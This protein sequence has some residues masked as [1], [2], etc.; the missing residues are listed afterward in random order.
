MN[1]NLLDENWIPVLYRDGRWGHVGIRKALEDASQI[2]NIAA[3]NPMDRLAILRF[4]LA[5]LYWCKGNPPGQA[6]P[7]SDD[8]FP[9]EWFS[10]LDTDRDYFN[11]LGEGKRFCQTSVAKRFRPVT[12]LLQEI[13]TGNNFWHF[14]HSIDHEDGLCLPCCAMGLLRL[15]LFSVSGLR[16]LNA[17]INGTPPVYVVH[18]GVSL[19]DALRANWAPCAELGLPAWVSPDIHLTP[20]DDVPLLTGL[21]MLSRRVWLQDP[22]PKGGCVACGGEKTAIVRACEFQT[23]GRQANERWTDPHVVYLD[24]THRKSLKAPDLTA[25][26]KFSMDRPWPDLLCRLLEVKSLGCGS[27]PRS[28]LVVGFATNKA[29]NVDVWERII[30]AP[31]PESNL[32]KAAS[33][34]R[35]WQKENSALGSQLARSRVENAPKTEREGRVKRRGNDGRAAISTIRPHVEGIVSADVGKLLAGDD[36]AWEQA[37]QEYSP[38]MEAIA[39][40]LSPGFT[41]KAIVGRNRIAN[42][43][44]NMRTAKTKAPTHPKGKK[45]GGQ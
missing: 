40:A 10:R 17:G 31:P 16:D 30:H 11:L 25:P 26:R 21:T 9:S 13:P 23:A 14:R 8:S 33:S 3:S 35:R 45:G 44:P 20:D 28:L 2:R 42:V 38:M 27:K 18:W 4:L 5:L 15:P 24:G 7:L 43:L 32:E 1:Y 39:G 34:I 22:E 12:D 37:A 29:K 6:G 36:A 19:L 41:T